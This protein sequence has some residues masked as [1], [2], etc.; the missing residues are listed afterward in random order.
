MTRVEQIGDATLYLGDFRDI[1]PDLPPIDTLVSDPPYGMEFRSN[2]RAVKHREIAND[3]DAELLKLACDYPVSH[4]RYVFCRW[5]NLTDVPKPKSL[6]TWVKNNWS[7]GDLEHEHGRQT[8]VILFYPGPHHFFPR[9]R[10]SDVV[11]AQRTGN[12]YHPHRKTSWAYGRS[13]A[14]DGRTDPRSILRVI[15]NRCCGCS[16]GAQIHRDRT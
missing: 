4:S 7:M 12:D 9:G 5:D 11:E 15:F 16:C 2:H 1:R 8:E 6:I 3:D 10:P 13:S 14:V